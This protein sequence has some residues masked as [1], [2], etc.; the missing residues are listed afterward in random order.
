MTALEQFRNYLI[1]DRT[2]SD[3][4]RVRYLAGMWD[5]FSRSWRGTPEEWDEWEAGPKGAY[6]AKDLNRVTLAASY[7]LTKLA[8]AGYRIPAGIVPA[9]MVS[10]LVDP[11]GSGTAYGALFYCGEPVT[12][13][14]EPIGSSRFLGWAENGERVSEDPVYTFTANADCTL[15]AEFEASWVVESSIVGAGRIGTA[16]LGRGIS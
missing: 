4:E 5:P 14:A 2:Q 16:I 15:T 13:R 11:P 12:V 3:V 6:N 7:L 8:E 10:V 9:F 1:T